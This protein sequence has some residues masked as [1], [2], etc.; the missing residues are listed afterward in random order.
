MRVLLKQLS[1]SLLILGL[2]ACLSSPSVTF[3]ERQKH[4]L[5]QFPLSELRVWRIVEGDTCGV[6][7]AELIDPNGFVHTVKAGDYIGLQNGKVI[8]I[9]KDELVLLEIVKGEDGI[10][11]EKKRA[12]PVQ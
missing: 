7:L 1:F 8:Q 12:L 10:W 4:A 9:A 5:E 6:V 11:M 2:A 3:A